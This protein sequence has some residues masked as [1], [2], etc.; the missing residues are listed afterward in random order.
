MIQVCVIARDES[1]AAQLQR[2]LRRPGLLETVLAFGFAADVV[3]VLNHTQVDLIVVD[4]TDDEDAAI[5]KAAEIMSEHVIPV[6]VLTA[7]ANV[8]RLNGKIDSTGSGVIG[9]LHFPGDDARGQE[10]AIRQ[11]LLLS[12]VKVIRRWDAQK[13]ES[14]SRLAPTQS[15]I[16]AEPQ[17]G[18]HPRQTPEPHIV[19]VGASA[20]GTKALQEIVL[21]LPADFPLPIL[22]VQHL[23]PGYVQG[24]ARWLRQQSSINV[25]VAEQYVPLRPETLYIAPDDRH[26]TVSRDNRIVLRDDAAVNG[27]RPSIGLLFTSALDAFGSSTLAV[28][29]SGMGNDGAH[30]MRALY[31]HGATTLVQDKESSLIHGIPGEAIKLG[32]ARHILPVQQIAPALLTLSGYRAA[33]YKNH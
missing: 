14:L 16:A 31:E 21:H 22:V 8:L 20:G 11:L 33:P 30:E 25:L 19:V 23:A 15:A 13:Y 18:M 9:V 12:E 32:A 7:A 5:G 2:R 29:L 28:L 26:L 24:F 4:A 10:Q 1:L 3:G 6:V 27:F 17:S